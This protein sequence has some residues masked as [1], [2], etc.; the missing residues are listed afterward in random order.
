MDNVSNNGQH[1]IIALFNDAPMPHERHP[2]NYLSYLG[3]VLARYRR[4][5]PREH[6]SAKNFGKDVLAKYFGQ[7]VDRNRIAR[8]EKGDPT[9]AFG[10]YAAY[11]YEMGV[12]PDLLKTLEHGRSGNL[13]YLLLVERELA[14]DIQQ[15][16]N[17]AHENL[18]VRSEQEKN[19]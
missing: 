15:S 4:S 1:S 10:V 12:L 9:V 16:I 17:K 5:L 14:P 8:A 6:R 7:A 11:L 18:R 3:E 2:V 13:R 19:R